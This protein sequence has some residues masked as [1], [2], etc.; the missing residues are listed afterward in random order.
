MNRERC[1][2]C[3][4]PI[5]LCKCGGKMKFSQLKELINNYEQALWSPSR[6]HVNFG[7]DCGCGGDTYTPESW[8]AEEQQAAVD[9]ALMKLWCS[10]HNI[11]WDGNE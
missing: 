10:N 3:W 11:E 6:M 8:D 9:I 1:G 7:C 4:N 5:E 2:G